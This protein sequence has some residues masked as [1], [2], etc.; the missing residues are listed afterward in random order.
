MDTRAFSRRAPRRWEV[1]A[2][3]SPAEE[4][5]YGVKRIAGLPG[6]RIS[7]RDGDVLANG[8]VCRKSLVQLRA[9]AVTVHDDR[10]RPEKAEDLPARWRGETTA[11]S[12]QTTPEG[13]A[14]GLARSRGEPDWV[15]YHHWPCVASHLPRSQ[16]VPVFDNDSYNQGVGRGSLLQDVRDLFLSCRMTAHGNGSVMLRLHDGREWLQVE[17]FPNRGQAVLRRAKTELARAEFTRDA[18]EHGALVEFAICD[19]RALLAIESELLLDYPLSLSQEVLYPVANPVGIGAAGVSMDVKELRLLRDIH[20]LDPQNSGRPWIDQRRLAGDEYFV[21][22]D[23]SPV[24][25]DSRFWP[26]EG[27]RR[28]TLLGSVRESPNR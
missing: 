7:I 20:Y 5:Q 23:N 8:R 2:L 4:G 10:Y 17:L 15:A 12:W 3:R 6:E 1:V 22:G 28:R 26:I 14:C 13:Y 11:T 18:L 9:V 21:L 24:S 25:V 27:V 19:G 16:E